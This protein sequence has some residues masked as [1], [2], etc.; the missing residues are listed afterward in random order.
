ME[1]LKMMKENL[2]SSV[3]G[4]MSHLDQVDAKEL[5]EAIDMIKDLSE[6]MYYCSIVKAMEEKDHEEAKV[7][8]YIEPKIY[9][10]YYPMYRDIDRDYGRMYYDGRG[11]HTTGTGHSNSGSTGNRGYSEMRLPVEMRD[12]REG[13]SPASRK[14]YMEAKEMHH[15]KAT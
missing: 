4:Q 9:E 8:H 15:D 5:G 7:S 3:M 6:A 2:M 1:R 13:R 11:V 12:R 10:D 14:T